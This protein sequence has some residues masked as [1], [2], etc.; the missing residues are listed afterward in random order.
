MN[1]VIA[2]PPMFDL[3][4]EVFDIRDKPVIFTWGNTIFNPTGAHIGP[5]LK[6][7]EGVHYQQQGD[8]EFEIRHWWSRY[9]VDAEFR[10]AQELPAH[11]AEY[12]CFKN[13]HRDRNEVSWFLNQT[14]QRL[15]SSLY[16]GLLSHAQARKEIMK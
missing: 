11:R 12:H 4:A 9:L 8:D 3:I 16:G 1:I 10:L 13:T 7:H 14:A 6:C 5:E 2:K 15:S